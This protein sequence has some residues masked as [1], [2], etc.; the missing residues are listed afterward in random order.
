[1]TT[2]KA[3]E[4]A[5]QIDTPLATSEADE[6]W[7]QIS[8]AF[9]DN[10]LKQLVS[11]QGGLANDTTTASVKDEQIDAIKALITTHSNQVQ[12]ELLDRLE[13]ERM[14]NQRTCLGCGYN[15]W[16]LHCPHDG[17]QNPCPNCKLTPKQVVTGNCECEL[18]V[19]LDS[20]QAER[21]RLEGDK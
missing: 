6:L 4:G 9:M 3:H 11:S 17:Y 14:Y 1:M 8:K 10:W 5:S 2:S 18:V 19:P 7:K 20:L 12:R 16:G 21:K 13:E 15:W